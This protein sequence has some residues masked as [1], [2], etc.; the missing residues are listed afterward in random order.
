MTSQLH[1]AGYLRAGRPESERLVADSI[2]AVWGYVD[3]DAVSVENHYFSTKPLPFALSLDQPH[4]IETTVSEKGIG[5]SMRGV[6]IYEI[7]RNDLRL[8][9]VSGSTEPYGAFGFAPGPDG[10][11]TYT[12][13]VVTSLISGDV[14]YS[15]KLDSPACLDQFG[16]GTTTVDCLLDGGKRDRVVWGGDAAIM[17]PPLAYSTGDMK[18]LR[19]A[20]RFLASWRKSDGRFA[21]AVP[22]TH[23]F[24]PGVV[25]DAP[26]TFCELLDFPSLSML[27][28]PQTSP[29]GTSSTAYRR[30]MMPGCT[31]Q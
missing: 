6:V 3:E 11:A 8:S 27:S 16:A 19:E 21:S 9:V 7:P 30:S 25:E 18:A 22:P 13:V 20:I 26:M 28:T 15:S 2:S 31:A 5:V 23:P 24:G 1:R 29:W 4:T 17:G 14:I 10:L 12:N